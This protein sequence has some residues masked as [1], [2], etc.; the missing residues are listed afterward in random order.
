MVGGVE[1]ADLEVRAWVVLPALHQVEL[2]AFHSDLV[3]RVVRASDGL[4]PV[5]HRHLF[6]SLRL[7]ASKL[8]P[9]L[10]LKYQ[11]FSLLTKHSLYK[12]EGENMHNAHMQLGRLARC[13]LLQFANAVILIFQ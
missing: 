8:T 10:L 11:R 12:H 5:K 6:L 2:N 7:V 4:L 3:G 13:G 1:W 9:S